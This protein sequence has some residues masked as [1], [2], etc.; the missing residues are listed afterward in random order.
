MTITFSIINPFHLKKSTINILRN[1][2]EKNR[3][4]INKLENSTKKIGAEL[5]NPFPT[6][7]NN[8]PGKLIPRV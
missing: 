1:S 5:K 8:L 2:S 3:S 7:F 4:S 6:F